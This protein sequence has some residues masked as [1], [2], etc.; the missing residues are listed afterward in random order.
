MQDAYT[1]L[2]YFRNNLRLRAMM[3]DNQPWFVAHDKEVS[4]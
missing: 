3:I 1:P 2:V 4:A